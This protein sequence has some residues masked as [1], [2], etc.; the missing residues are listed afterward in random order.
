MQVQATTFTCVTFTSSKQSCPLPQTEGKGPVTPMF[1]TAGT[2]SSQHEDS[3]AITKEAAHTFSAVNDFQTTGITKKGKPHAN[4]YTVRIKVRT[5]SFKSPQFP[6]CLSKVCFLQLTAVHLYLPKPSTRK[7][8][9]RVVK[10][11]ASPFSPSQAALR[12]MLARDQPQL[13]KSKP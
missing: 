12:Q 4:T 13:P 8:H 10:F 7:K 2:L 5:C 3:G 9:S 6:N 1:C 11:Y